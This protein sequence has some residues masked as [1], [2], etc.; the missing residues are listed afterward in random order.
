MNDR[1]LPFKFLPVKLAIL[2]IGLLVTVAIIVQI[3]KPSPDKSPQLNGVT[4]KIL[5]E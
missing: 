4:Q 3:P 2:W 5:G 1:F